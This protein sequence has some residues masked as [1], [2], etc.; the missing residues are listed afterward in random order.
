LWN[1]K[2]AELGVLIDLVLTNKQRKLA[3]ESHELALKLFLHVRLDEQ[4]L[5]KVVSLLT[6]PADIFKRATD[7]GFS[8]PAILYLLSHNFT[9]T[10]LLLRK[11]GQDPDYLMDAVNPTFFGQKEALAALLEACKPSRELINADP[12]GRYAL[13]FSA[14]Q[15]AASQKIYR[16]LFP[17]PEEP[18]WGRKHELGMPLFVARAQ[19]LGVSPVYALG[20]IEEIL[21]GDYLGVIEVLL[22]YGADPRAE[23]QIEVQG[24]NENHFGPFLEMPAYQVAE[25]FQLPEIAALL[26]SKA[27]GL[28]E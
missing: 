9:P 6:I 4:G 27:G 8:Q 15:V 1:P 17:N 18:L 19:K 3:G 13:L 12:F 2:R 10:Y 22:R 28:L 24:D 25:R 21:E 14:L 16:T 5:Q 20:H 26:R 7:R 11:E 23:F